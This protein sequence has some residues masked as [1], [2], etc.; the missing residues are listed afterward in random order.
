MNAANNNSVSDSLK[1]YKDVK[2][3]VEQKDSALGHTSLSIN[4]GNCRTLQASTTTNINL[5]T[6]AGQL[7]CGSTNMRDG[8]GPISKANLLDLKQLVVKER[9]SRRPSPRHVK[10]D[11][12][13]AASLEKSCRLIKKLHTERGENRV[14]SLYDRFHATKSGG[15]RRARKMYGVSICDVYEGQQAPEQDMFSYG[16][17]LA[18]PIG[19]PPAKQKLDPL[20][21]IK[22]LYANNLQSH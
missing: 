20:M 14:P 6:T 2:T 16:L 3:G 17:F 5:E 8:S 22:P 18:T 13:K 12:K 1:T 9:P 10:T 4:M 15:K 11:K 7:H 21:N 19:T